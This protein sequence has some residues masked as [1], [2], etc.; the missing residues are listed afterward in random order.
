MLPLYELIVDEV[1]VNK[2]FLDKDS[3]YEMIV[4]KIS[5]DKVIVD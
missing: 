5:V 4:D 2:I 3:V 1:S